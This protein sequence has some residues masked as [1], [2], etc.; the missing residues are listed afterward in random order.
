VIFTL[1]MP[2]STNNL[3]SNAGSKRRKSPAYNR[4]IK[5]AG[6]EI[7]VQRVGQK[8][9]EPPFYISVWI[10]PPDDGRRRDASN[11][12]KAPED[13]LASIFGFDDNLCVDQSAHKRPQS[14]VRPYCHVFLHSTNEPSVQDWYMALGGKKSG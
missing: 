8:L 5:K 9:P 1:P 2:P 6:P 14:E 13:L 10:Y 11:F 3:Y 4:W 7:T 12:V